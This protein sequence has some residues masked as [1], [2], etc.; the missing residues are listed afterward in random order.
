[1]THSESLSG[2]KVLITRP[3]QQSET[4]ASAVRNL[5]GDTFDFPLLEI[6]AI[7]DEFKVSALEQKVKNLDGYDKLIFISKNA[8]VYGAEVIN[9]NWSDLPTV[10]EV[11]AIGPSTAKLATDFF[12][13]EVVHPNSGSTSEDLI[14]LPCLAN[15]TQKRI[16]I[17]RGEYGRE[18]LAD[19][20]IDRGAE[21]EYLDVYQRS[22]T[23]RRG[24]ELL[25][26]ISENHV[27]VLTITSGDSLKV[28]NR[29]FLESRD[30]C[31]ELFSI[32]II[33]PSA[34]V[35]RLAEELG[36]EQVSLAQGADTG[37]MVFALH[38]IASENAKRN[39]N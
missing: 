31:S 25:K 6:S 24:R 38:E 23:K 11:I 21:V 33:V 3:K 27:N 9:K 7:K 28:L 32:P 37:A 17:F 1:M 36:F 34:R 26:I 15:V 39:G 10:S 35:N 14:A 12:G 22:A 30:R 2:L 29:L 18:F 13:C 8:V 5:G 16:A 20:L 4:L 19:S